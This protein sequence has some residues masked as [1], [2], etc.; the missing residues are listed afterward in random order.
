M[1]SERNRLYNRE[2]LKLAR[3]K[4]IKKDREKQKLAKIK[5]FK[6]WENNS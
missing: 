4:Q 1:D 5:G 3:N 6:K 2:P